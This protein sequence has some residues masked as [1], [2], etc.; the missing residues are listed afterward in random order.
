[1]APIRQSLRGGMIQE[2]FSRALMVISLI[3][4]LACIFEL[5]SLNYKKRI[6]KII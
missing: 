3:V 1:M 4:F 6:S 5:T 2:S